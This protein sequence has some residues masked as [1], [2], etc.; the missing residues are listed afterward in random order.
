MIT[1]DPHISKQ[2]WELT[3][4]EFCMQNIWT[5]KLN[6]LPPK[7]DDNFLLDDPG[8]WMNDGYARL[9]WNPTPS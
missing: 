9:D 8:I 1:V 2:G 6:D 5:L 7:I 3:L 4:F